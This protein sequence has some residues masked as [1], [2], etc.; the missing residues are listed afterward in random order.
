[1]SITKILT[2]EKTSAADKLTA[3]A[4]IVAKAREAYGNADVKIAASDVN[5]VHGAM[6]FAHLE[7]ESKVA[8]LT[9]EVQVIKA[10]AIELT[11]QTTGTVLDK[12]VEELLATNA[13]FVNAEPS[14]EVNYI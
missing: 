2:A 13:L 8:M 3:V 5:T 6:P 4:E 12:K 7:D 1:M 10:R 11:R 14:E 9:N